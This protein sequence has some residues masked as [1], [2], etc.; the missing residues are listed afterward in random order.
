MKLRK[1]FNCLRDH[2]VKDCTFGN[3]CRRCDNAGEKKHFFL[4][5][6]KSTYF[7][8]TGHRPPETSAEPAVTMRNVKTESIKAAYNRVTAARVVNPATGHS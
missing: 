6:E 8:D 2:F 1:C 3:N 5:R 4:L 7:V